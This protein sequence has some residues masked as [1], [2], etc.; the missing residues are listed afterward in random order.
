[1]GHAIVPSPWRS[2][3]PG[4][5][6]GFP[7]A[8]S[9]REPGWPRTRAILLA[10][11]AGPLTGKEE[12]VEQLAGIIDRTFPALTSPV[13]VA[14][15][16]ASAQIPSPRHRTL[17]DLVYEFELEESLENPDL[18]V[19]M[20]A[21]RLTEQGHVEIPDFGPFQ[22][23]DWSRRQCASLA[24]LR[25]DRW[26]ENASPGD[27]AEEMNRRFERAS[28]AVR[29]RTSRFKD[30]SADKEP[31]A[32]GRLRAFVSPGYTP[33]RDSVVASALVM[34]LSSVDGELRIIRADM[35]DRSTSFVVGVGKPFRMGDDHD[36]GDIWGGLLVRNSGVGFASL[37]FTLHL[38]RL[39]CKN[40]MTAPVGDAMLLRRRHRGRDGDKLTGLLAERM[41]GL[42]GQL[43]QGA[44][45][46]RAAAARRVTDVE[47]DV[48]GLLL[49]A[50]L[51]V[52]L[53]P[54]VVA[55]YDQEPL[56]TAFGVSQAATLAAQGL[57][58]EER[59][60]LEGAAGEYLEHFN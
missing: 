9:S 46:L 17:H 44:E 16:R 8:L 30:E 34:A 57:A 47:G 29:L 25:W 6:P 43:R 60:Q 31:G 59:L 33:V 49:A 3:E 39:L 22:F 14:G 23:T 21:L 26:F 37:L 54:A 32:H 1:M 53:L 40:G 51:P 50:R 15:T 19:P 18:T 38:T 36:I 35:T 20:K 27:R 7:G 52:R 41:D 42:P 2:G 58:P 4:F 55:A 11:G 28:G 48:R 12:I 10:C 24:G 5:L 45:V 56:P 13:P